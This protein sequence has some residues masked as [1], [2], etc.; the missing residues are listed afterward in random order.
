MH[1]V[2]VRSNASCH[3]QLYNI[4]SHTRDTETRD[5]MLSLSD[6]RTGGRHWPRKHLNTR[7]QTPMYTSKAVYGDQFAV[8][9]SVHGFAGVLVDGEPRGREA[10]KGGARR[11]RARRSGEHPNRCCRRPSRVFSVCLLPG[12]MSDTEE[13]RDIEQI[14]FDGGR[15]PCSVLGL[16]EHR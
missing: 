7:P 6:P 9:S 8:R 2:T 11:G 15:A 13:E 16:G 5:R 1:W 12:V 14:A 4:N 10:E 3:F